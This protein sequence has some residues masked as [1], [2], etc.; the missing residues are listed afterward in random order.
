MQTRKHFIAMAKLLSELPDLKHR[1]HLALM[2]A[3]NFAKENPR[4]DR[5]RF[6]IACDLPADTDRV[7]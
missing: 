2:N 5:E 4:F 7:Q 1:R 6:F 3:E